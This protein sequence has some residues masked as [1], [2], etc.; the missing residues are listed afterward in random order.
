VLEWRGDGSWKLDAK[1]K[2]TGKREKV[3]SW[4]VEDKRRLKPAATVGV[5]VG[6]WKR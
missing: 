1:R 5:G 2:K 4:R 3:G 6:G